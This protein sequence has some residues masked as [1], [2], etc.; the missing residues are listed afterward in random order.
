M[1]KDQSGCAGADIM[2]RITVNQ[3]VQAVWGLSD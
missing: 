1:H 2:W 3:P